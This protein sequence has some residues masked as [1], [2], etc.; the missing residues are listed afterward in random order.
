[1]YS[2][3]GEPHIAYTHFTTTVGGAVSG[4]PKYNYVFNLF[5]YLKYLEKKLTN[6]S[7]Y[8]AG[9]NIFESPVSQ[10]LCIPA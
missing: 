9:R 1:M 8:S 10:G 3:C 7:V 4:F 5:F 2:I 6:S